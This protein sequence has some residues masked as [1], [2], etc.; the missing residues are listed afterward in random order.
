[1]FTKNAPK[2]SEEHL[3]FIHSDKVRFALLRDKDTESYSIATAEA[4][5]GIQPAISHSG[6]TREQ[7]QEIRTALRETHTEHLAG[8]SEDMVQAR[9]ITLANL[10]EVV[11]TTDQELT[12]SEEIPLT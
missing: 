8:K 10:K 1:M 9:A 4:G 12:A 3:E 7:A 5:E 11:I 6:L 2:G